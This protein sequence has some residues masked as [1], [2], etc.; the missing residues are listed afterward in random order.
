M[1]ATNCTA[2]LCFPPHC[3][4]SEARR[5]AAAVEQQEGQ[6][7]ELRVALEAERRERFGAQQALAASQGEGAAAR[8][9]ADALLGQL[10]AAEAM[11]SAVEGEGG[12]GLGM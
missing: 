5:W 12:G 1:L 11:A 4:A 8:E 10:R 9:D 6:L 3:R 2:C 7:A